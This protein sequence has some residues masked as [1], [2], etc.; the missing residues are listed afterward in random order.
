VSID[1]DDG[2]TSA[3]QAGFSTM[4]EFGYKGTAGVVTDY[5]QNQALYNAQYM[6]PAMVK[7]L[8]SRGHAIASHTLDHTSLISLPVAD[9][10]RQIRDSKSYLE[11]L[12][13]KPVNY[14]ITPY[15]D[16]NP[17][18]TAVAKTYYSIGV[19]NCDSNFNTRSTYDRYN[20]RSFP[21]FNTTTNQE[22]A[23]ALDEAKT[24]NYWLVLMYHEVNNNNTQYSVTATQLR[25]QLQLIKD[26]G[27]TVKTS[28]DAIAEINPQI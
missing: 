17:Q 9:Y 6:T 16:N 22:I 5:T 27:L 8:D 20:V 25:S 19:R 11:T 28:Q 26:R 7:N 13:G 1:F 14:L 3:Y 23:I 2:W 24:K 18:V 10:T 4:D 12:L 15:C 21:I